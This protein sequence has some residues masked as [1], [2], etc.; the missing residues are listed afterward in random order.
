MQVRSGLFMKDLLKIS[1]YGAED[2]PGVAP[3]CVLFSGAHYDL[4]VQVV[5]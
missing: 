5:D 1:E 3:I 2:F 4:L